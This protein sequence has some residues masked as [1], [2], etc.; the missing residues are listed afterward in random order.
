MHAWMGNLFSRGVQ[1]LDLE[2]MS[3]G[4]LKYWNEWHSKVSRAERD[5]AR[6][7]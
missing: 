7:T 1:P 6:G 3:F 4:Q 2:K 5:A